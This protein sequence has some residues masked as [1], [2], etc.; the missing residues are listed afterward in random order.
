MGLNRDW[1]KISKS[2]S[3]TIELNV[4]NV[5]TNGQKE[6]IDVL[7][8]KYSDFNI[9]QMKYF[10][11]LLKERV[12]DLTSLPFLSVNKNW[13]ELTEK[14]SFIISFRQFSYSER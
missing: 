10:G 14:C 11:E 1:E 3:K 9:L 5:L 13:Q 7:A 8:R 12:D 2:N 6:Y 4:S